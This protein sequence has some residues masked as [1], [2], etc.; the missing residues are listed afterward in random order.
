MNQRTRVL[1]GLTAGVLAVSAMAFGFSKWS[2][3]INLNGSVSANGKWDVA[4]TAASAQVSGTGAQMGAIQ[5]EATYNVVT[6]PVYVHYNNGYYHYYVG[7]DEAAVVSMSRSEFTSKYQEPDKSIGVSRFNSG[8]KSGDYTFALNVNENGEAINAG[9]QNRPSIEAVDNGEHD[10]QQIGTAIAWCF[11]GRS[12][13]TPEND[14]IQLTWAAA[15]D[16]FAEHK[17]SDAVETVDATCDVTVYPITVTT[18]NG[19][20][21]FQVDDQ[22]PQTVAVTKAQLDAYDQQYTLNQIYDPDSKEYRRFASGYK[23]TDNTWKSSLT[24]KICFNEG[25]DASD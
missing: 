24:A 11:G 3:E 18:S 1:T 22:N 14:K 17:T 10:G 8:A 23:F 13:N 6:Y 21:A 25:F 4:V 12:T 15:R 9:A 19:Y 20:Y 16:Y 2:S 5:G 7:D